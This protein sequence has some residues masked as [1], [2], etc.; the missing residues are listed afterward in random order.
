MELIVR[1]ARPEDAAGALLYE[2]AK[3]YYD[4]YAG[5]EARARRLLTRVYG[6]PAH[7]ASWE[8]CHVAEGGGEVVGVLAG[9]PSRR[10]EELAH[11]FIVLTLPRI[12]P[13]RWPGLI[14]HLQAAGHVAPHPPVGSWYVDA[15][16]VRDDWRR[17]GVARALLHE[18]EH[19]AE[20]SGSTGVA[21][22][23]GLANA[24]ARALYEA[25]G[26]TRGSLRRAPDARIA[27]AIGGPGFV[28]Y[29]KRRPRNPGAQ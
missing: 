16:A 8:F 22:D 21:L 4:A 24:P 10:A 5:T 19:Q 18:A 20:R 27:D 11:R 2:S 17:R 9:F 23:T 29:F 3:P 7:S 25:C 28:S 15:L 13:W 26:Y 12:P 1:P 6:R 14:R